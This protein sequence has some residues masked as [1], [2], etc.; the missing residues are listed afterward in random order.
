M[1]KSK[2]IP[3][4]YR[5]KFWFKSNPDIVRYGE[6]QTYHEEAK[7][8]WAD[9]HK[10]VVADALTGHLVL[11][12]YDHADIV[13]EKQPLGWGKYDEETRMSLDTDYDKYLCAEYKKQMKIQRKAGKGVK[14]G[15]LCSIG[16]AD[17]CATYVITKVNKKTCKVEWRAFGGGDNY[18]DHRWGYG[19]TVPM[20]EARMYVNDFDLD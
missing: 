10:L 17:G 13:I 16:V 20:D 19:K 14:A 2:D 3:D 8:A 6:V 7:Q 1:P 11:V 9:G 15:K 18:V 4:L 12:P 5:I